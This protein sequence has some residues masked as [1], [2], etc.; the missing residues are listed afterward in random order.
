MAVLKMI[1]ELEIMMRSELMNVRLRA[2]K[3]NLN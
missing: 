3:F 2:I 1:T